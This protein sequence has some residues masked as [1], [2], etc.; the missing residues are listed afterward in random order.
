VAGAVAGWWRR[1]VA[2]IVD[3]LILSIPNAIIS[4][5][6]GIETTTVDEITDEVT[7]DLGALGAVTL[8]SLVVS[9]VYSG[10]LEGSSHGQTVGKMALRIQVRD[11]D[12][13][14]PIGFGRAA[15]RRFIYQVLFLALAI[16]GIINGLSPLW[17]SRR[18]AWHDKA[19][20]TLVV[21]S[22]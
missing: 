11:A 17:D 14:G 1:L 4:F 18:Q 3:G 9:V 2:V 5:L 10:L 13:G 15:M 12:G 22:S 8:I 20:N 7:V 16:P 6:L 21:N 19:A